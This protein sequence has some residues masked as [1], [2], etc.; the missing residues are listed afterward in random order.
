MS[1]DELTLEQ[2]DVDGALR[3]GAAALDDHGRGMTRAGLLGGGLFGAAALAAIVADPAAAA[4]TSKRDVTILNFALTLEYLEA[5]FYAEAVK[6]GELKGERLVFAQVAGAHERTH[7]RFLKKALGSAAIPRPSF[8]FGRTT[9]SAKRFTTTAIALEETGVAAY[10]GQA[11]RIQSDA[12]LGAALTIHSV[13]AR[14]AAWIRDI[15][16]RNPAPKGLD[17]PLT[18]AQVSAIV[19]RTGFIQ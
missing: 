3:E 4:R 2:V 14:H 16:G 8:D 9:S 7:V 19:A 18:K 5:A 13:E 10:K 6:R 17:Q 1:M 15:A 12:I 11:P